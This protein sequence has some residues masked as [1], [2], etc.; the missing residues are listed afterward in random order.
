VIPDDLLVR[1]LCGK[2]GYAYD[3]AEAIGVSTD[4]LRHSAR[5]LE[6]EGHRMTRTSTLNGVEYS[7]QLP[8]R[9]CQ[10]PGCDTLLSRY[11]AGRYC[12]LHEPHED[13]P[14]EWFLPWGGKR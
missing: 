10:E 9:C 6:D 13:L 4:Q 11:N 1:R 8:T 3:I 7:Y 14:Q 2:R 12:A 5:R